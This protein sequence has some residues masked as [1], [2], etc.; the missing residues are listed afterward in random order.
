M[1]IE[2]VKT[3]F[4]DTFAFYLKAQNF[5]WNVEGKDFPQYHQFFGDLYSEVYGSIDTFAELIRTL[6]TYAPG[7]LAR[8]KELSTIQENDTIPSA[9]E[10]VRILSQDNDSVRMS[11]AIA[12]RSAEK[13]GELG[14]AN[15]LQDRIQAHDKHG[16]MLKAT[17]K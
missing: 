8:V 11:L 12:F 14:L 9:L 5:H 16:W 4:A 15:F 13:E 1:L 2:Q 17:L 3:A 6:N 10:M 7:T